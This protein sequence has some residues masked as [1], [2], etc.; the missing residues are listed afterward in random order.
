MF[1]PSKKQSC[2]GQTHAAWRT[3]AKL[4]SVLLHQQ[5]TQINN[6][7]TEDLL[8]P[9]FFF[10]SGTCYIGPALHQT[11]LLP[12]MQKGS[13]VL[14]GRCEVRGAIWANSPRCPVL[15]GKSCTPA[16]Q[17]VFCI[18]REDFLFHTYIRSMYKYIC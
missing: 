9:V 7:Q 17:W 2:M 4:K 8:G 1:Y 16:P 10:L 5:L 13:L 11:Q 15:F 14:L 6:S 12:Q 3:A 18:L